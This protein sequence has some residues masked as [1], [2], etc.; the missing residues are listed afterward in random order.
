MLT[1]QHYFASRLVDCNYKPDY[2]LHMCGLCH[3]LG[4]TYGFFARLL[5]NH[6]MI[7]L[8]TLTSAQ[9]LA[10]PTPV[11][12]RCPLNPA[13]Q[14]RTN[15]D[16]ASQFAAAAAVGLAYNSVEDDRVDEG[17][18]RAWAAA[19]WLRPLYRKAID[20][21][22]AC[23][24]DATTLHALTREQTTAEQDGDP[25]QPSALMSARFFASTARLADQPDNEA[26]LAIIGANYG[27]YLYL[28]D[29]YRDY[30]RDML[31]GQYNPLRTYTLQTDNGYE[32]TLTGV[33]WLR[34]QL[35]QIAQEIAA[36]LAALR[37]YRYQDM[38]H[39]LLL[40]PIQAVITD[41]S[42]PRE[43]WFVPRTRAADAL[44][45]GLFLEVQEGDGA[46]ILP[47]KKRYQQ[48][49]SWCDSPECDDNGACSC[50][51]SG[52][53][54]CGELGSNIINTLTACLT[55]GNVECHPFACLPDSPCDNLDLGG[56]DSCNGCD[57]CDASGCSN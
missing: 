41:I 37:L 10:E 56:C 40:E 20:S 27:A 34:D 33:H 50:N 15:Q 52:L 6:E 13:R 44:K 36:Q 35:Q 46:P 18:L 42:Q 29:A 7:L 54:A 47:R 9:Q 17:G 55:P 11:L 8:N 38:L 32:L 24:F 43:R 22:Q 2:R 48:D 16:A 57:N 30:P 31:R 28:L 51:P 14:V 4:D 39:S 26:A 12:R 21:L 3:A 49:T 45:A 25:V 53:F 5:T 23:Q 19:R 1:Q